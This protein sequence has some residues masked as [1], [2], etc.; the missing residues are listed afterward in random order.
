LA[1]VF[2]TKIDPA[3]ANIIYSTYLGGS[4]LDRA[5]GIAVD[6][7]GNA[8]IVGR[9]DSTSMDFP[10]T[11]GSFGPAYRGGDFDW[12][13]FQTQRAR[14]RLDL[15]RLPRRRRKRFGLKASRLTAAGVGL[16]HRRHQ[17]ERIPEH[18]QCISAQR[19]GDTDAFLTKIN[20]GGS[21]FLYS[22]YLG[23]SGTDRGSGVGH[24]REWPGLRRRLWRFALT[25]PPRIHF[26]PAFGGNFDAVHSEVRHRRKAESIRWSSVRTWA[27]QAM[28]KLRD[29]SRCRSQ[30]PLRDRPDFIEQLSGVESGPAI[31]RRFVR[32]IH[33]KDFKRRHKGLR[34]LFRRQWRRSRNRGR[35]EFERRLSDRLSRRRPICQPSRR[36][37]STMEAR[38]TR[39]SPKLNPAGNAF[40][41]STYLG[42]SAN[43]NF[44]AAVTSTN[45]IAV[46]S[47]NAYVTGYTSSGNF[48]TQ[49]PLQS[50][51]AAGQDA[52]IAKIADVT[53]AADF[54]FSITPASRTINPGDATNYT[55][56]ATPTGGFT[57]NITLAVSGASGDTTTSF[58]PASITI[59]D[60]SPKSSTLTVTT[61]GATPPGRLFV[62]GHRHQRQPSAFIIRAT[63]RL[64]SNERES[65]ADEN[66][67]AKSG[68]H[69]GESHLSLDRHEQR[70]FARD[71]CLRDRQSAGRR[72]LCLGDADAG[73]LQRHDHGDVQSRF[74]RAKCVRHHQRRRGAAVGG[75]FNQQRECGRV[76]K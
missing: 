14:Q 69:A 28:T 47:S 67:V 27:A 44:V 71:E 9:V 42:G 57:G 19:A 65:I 43:E 45:P 74:A 24:R 37:S 52:F 18:R 39:S 4:G 59:T 5:D 8:F 41:Y 58:A 23:G 62:D 38:S 54:S 22:S 1:D 51:K 12:L 15:F 25:F 61:T 6:A 55:V 35:G 21:G 26:K 64:W 32:R 7:S 34:E 76:G 56:T 10:A 40:L 20:A 16:R 3:G 63:D 72:Q 29:C 17:V 73:F 70:S 33:R 60:A 66:G 30:Q 48:P 11:A 31:F 50:S 75:D 68:D 53:P 36:C 49:A 46:D 2:V 13:C